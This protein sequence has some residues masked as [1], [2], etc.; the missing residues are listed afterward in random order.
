M[1]VAYILVL[2]HTVSNPPVKPVFKTYKQAYIY[3]L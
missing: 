2:N 1:V 3:E